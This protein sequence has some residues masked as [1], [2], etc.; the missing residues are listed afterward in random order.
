MNV[1]KSR[2]FVGF[3]V[4]AL[5]FSGFLIAM[6]K[7]PL[8]WAC[9]GFILLAGLLAAAALL[10]FTDGKMSDYLTNLLQPRV[11]LLGVIL[12]TLCSIIVAALEYFAAY[13]M[14]VAWFCVLQLLILGITAIR[15]LFVGSASQAIRNVENHVKENTFDWKML[16]LDMDAIHRTSPSLKC[17]SDL[18]EAFRYADPMTHPGVSAIEETLRQELAQLKELCAAGKEEEIA[19]LCTKMQNDIRDRG[20]RLKMLK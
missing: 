16:R 11:L 9:W 5:V 2:I 3:V 7:T 18:Q 8:L 20:E 1:H 6:P 13:V 19:S 10:P 4:W 14:P 12:S 15:L 17:V